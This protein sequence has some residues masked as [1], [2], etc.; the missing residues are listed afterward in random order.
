LGPQ[1]DR[2]IV[3]GGAVERR[4][5]EGGCRR[6]GG[7]GPAVEAALDDLAEEAVVVAHPRHL[8]LQQRRVLLEHEVVAVHL[9]ALAHPSGDDEAEEVLEIGDEAAV[10]PSGLEFLDRRLVLLVEHG[11]RAAEEGL[12]L[13]RVVVEEGPTGDSAAFADIF[14]RD[15][16]IALLQGQIDG[17]AA[18]G[19]TAFALLALTQPF[20]R[21]RGLTVRT[22]CRVTIVARRAFLPQV[23]IECSAAHSHPVRSPRPLL[24]GPGSGHSPGFGRTQ[25]PS[26]ALARTGTAS[27]ALS[28]PDSSRST[29]SRRSAPSSEL[30]T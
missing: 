14:D 18:Q 13:R 26:F 24:Q 12:F 27:A 17:G 2:L 15:V 5:M 9:V 6:R 25:Y 20:C 10:G 30:R 22:Q 28:A 8:Q 4:L 21:F 1:R 23:Q 7:A 11:V 29:I 19:L 3:L 16:V